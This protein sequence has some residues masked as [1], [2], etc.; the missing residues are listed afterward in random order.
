MSKKTFISILPFLLLALSGCR[1]NVNDPL[2]TVSISWNEHACVIVFLAKKPF[3]VPP[4]VEYT[5]TTNAEGV[6]E[7]VLIVLRK[8]ASKTPKDGMYRAKAEMQSNKGAFTVTI[9][10]EN[11][12]VRPASFF[13][14][15]NLLGGEKKQ[16]G[17]IIPGS[18][19]IELTLE[20]GVERA[21]PGEFPVAPAIPVP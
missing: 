20:P 4:V 16:I 18:A 5:I 8:G 21:I 19:G 17:R 11:P 15:D 7:Y 12:T 13:L 9:P 10:L 14:Y 3:S 2:K 1:G 6:D